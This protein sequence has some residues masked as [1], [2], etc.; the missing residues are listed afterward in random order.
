MTTAWQLIQRLRCY[1]PDAPVTLDCWDL[2]IKDAI[3]PE[4]FV[5][6]RDDEERGTVIIISE[7]DNRERI[8]PEENLAPEKAADTST[9]KRKKVE[10]LRNKLREFFEDMDVVIKDDYDQEY[11]I[12]SFTPKRTAVEIEIRR[13]PV[14]DEE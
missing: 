7:N 10:E 9:F 3:E 11:Y 12:D 13:I 4:L 1:S 5:T 14:D 6:C 8:I 2:E